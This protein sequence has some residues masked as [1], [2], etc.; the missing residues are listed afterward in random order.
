MSEFNNRKDWLE[1]ELEEEENLKLEQEK[2]EEALAEKLLKEAEE[3]GGYEAD[4]VTGE[5]DGEKSE[6]DAGSPDEEPDEEDAGSDG[7]ALYERKSG[8]TGDSPAFDRTAKE[9][10][11]QDR[12]EERKDSFSRT[13]KG[14]HIS[15]RART[16]ENKETRTHV[17]KDGRELIRPTKKR[18]R[19]YITLGMIALIIVIVL[20]LLSDRIFNRVQGKAS[21]VLKETDKA[22]TY[23]EGNTNIQMHKGKLLRCSQDGLQCLNE[24]GTVAWDIPFT[25]SSPYLVTAGNY[26]SVAD[27][28]GMS[29]LIVNNGNIVTE[30][31]TESQILL[32]CVN[33]LGMSAAVLDAVDG[34]MVNLYSQEG[35]TLMQR[36]TYSTTDGIP[37]AI[38]LSA[39]GSRMGTVYVNYTGAV[40]TSILTIFDLTETGSSLVD[41]IVGSISFENTLLSDIKFVGNQC[42]YAGTDRFGAVSVRTDV[43]IQ[44]E[45]KVSYAIEALAIGEEFFAV[46]YG[47]G[48]A[49]TVLPAENNIVSYNYKG[50]VLAKRN[51]ENVNYL[52]VWGD[53]LVFGAGRY[54]EAISSTG[55]PKWTLQAYEEYSHMVQFDSDKTVAALRSGVIRFYK[56]K[57]KGVGE[58][59][60]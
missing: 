31:T 60:D 6:E 58:D 3:A 25:M 19:V 47:D 53:T 9:G 48:L 36:R 30:I 40:M 42:F 51:I 2:E 59:A 49:G 11:S 54:Y 37:M 1:R 18:Q 5:A 13:D 23:I 45:N 10:P 24:S 57:L 26:I 35:E 27:R 39:D 16:K 29:I 44:W 38:A 46:R 43:V 15:K 8:R 12:T 22:V 55:K 17:D 32:N 28:L 34:H 50:D 7:E 4:S 33:D 52:D 14:E 56:V 20:F 21:Y 41:R